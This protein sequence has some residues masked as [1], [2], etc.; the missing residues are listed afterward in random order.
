MGDGARLR[1]FVRNIFS[2]VP[3]M[4]P[5]SFWGIVSGVRSNQ[6]QVQNLVSQVLAIGGVGFIGSQIT[7]GLLRRGYGV[8]FLDDLLDGLKSSLPNR[9]SLRA[10]RETSAVRTR[11]FLTQN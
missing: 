7:E 3:H 6:I 2:E 9:G 10:H 4:I 1:F 5:C 11:N 8:G